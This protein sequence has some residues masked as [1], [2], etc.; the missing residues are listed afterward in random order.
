[1]ANRVHLLDLNSFVSIITYYQS[2]GGN[3]PVL[4]DRLAASARDRNQFRGHFMAVTAQSRATAI[5]IGLVM[6]G[7]L[8]V[9]AIFDMEH[10]RVF[11][12]SVNGWLLLGFAVLLQIIGAIWIYRLLRIPY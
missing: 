4:L 5:C 1:M 2:T 10:V 9:Y 7:L 8:V 6:I 11:F 12:H 3:L